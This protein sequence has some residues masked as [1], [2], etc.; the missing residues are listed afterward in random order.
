[1]HQ[2]AFVNWTLP[3]PAGELK[4]SQTLSP[5]PLGMGREGKGREETGEGER[6]EEGSIGIFFCQIRGYR[7]STVLCYY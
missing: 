1:M 3:G 4:C 6:V 5:Q 2:N 7:L